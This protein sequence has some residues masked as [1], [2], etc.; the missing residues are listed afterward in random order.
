MSEN[1]ENHKTILVLTSFLSTQVGRDH[2]GQFQI[3]VSNIELS[4][5]I[6]MMV[7][8]IFSSIDFIP[9]QLGV[10]IIPLKTYTI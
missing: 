5:G 7:L 10:E 4:N 3:V 6:S 1:H 9:Y 8:P 2:L